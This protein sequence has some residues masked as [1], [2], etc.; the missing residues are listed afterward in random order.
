MAQACQLQRFL[1]L[2]TGMSGTLRTV[3]PQEIFMLQCYFVAGGQPFCECLPTARVLRN[4]SGAARDLREL[5]G[6]QRP[7]GIGAGRIGTSMYWSRTRRFRG[8]AR[9]MRALRSFDDNDANSGRCGL[10]RTFGKAVIATDRKVRSIGPKPLG[11][12]GS[13]RR[14]GVLAT[15]PCKDRVRAPGAFSCF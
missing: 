10:R 14:Q 15:A 12:K 2:P 8:R 3:Y 11:G 6:T 4:R 13:G 5:S 7:L 9:V 1:D